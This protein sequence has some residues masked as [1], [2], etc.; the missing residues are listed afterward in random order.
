MG[1]HEGVSEIGLMSAGEIAAHLLD[2]CPS[3]RNFESYMFG[4]ALRGVGEDID[5]LIVGPGGDALCRLK[6]EMQAAGEC[7]PLHILYMQ[8]SEARCT[9]FVNMQ[10]CVLLAQLRRSPSRLSA[11][12]GVNITQWLPNGV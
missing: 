7:L 12:P 4:S 5:I 1:R 6:R 2:N 9:D 10:R 11:A 8:P 3:L